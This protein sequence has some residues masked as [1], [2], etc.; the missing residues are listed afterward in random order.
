MMN[1]FPALIKNGLSNCASGWGISGSWERCRWGQEE[2][3]RNAQGFL[4]FNTRAKDAAGAVAELDLVLTGGRLS[5]STKSVIEAAYTR[6]MGKGLELKHTY[7]TSV[8]KG[9]NPGKVV[10]CPDEPKHKWKAVKQAQCLRAAREMTPPNTTKPTKLNIHTR[11]MFS[12]RIMTPAS[13]RKLG[14][15]MAPVP[16]FL[17]PYRIPHGFTQDPSTDE[18][19]CFAWR[20]AATC[21]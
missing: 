18:G 11:R 7:A 3:L 14:R 8:L 6:R 2:T 12:S 5:N 21:A 1:G 17:I 20:R 10:T 15:R 9:S 19:D 4:T 16:P 13:T